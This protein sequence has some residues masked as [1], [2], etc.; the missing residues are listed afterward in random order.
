LAFARD[1]Q[2]LIFHVMFFQSIIKGERCKTVE[3]FFAYLK[4]RHEETVA[5]MAH[6]GQLESFLLCLFEQGKP[7]PRINWIFLQKLMDTDFQTKP[8]R[9]LSL[10]Q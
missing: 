9:E 3:P 10:K 4:V 2:D 7:M 8:S 1:A 6:K 5:R